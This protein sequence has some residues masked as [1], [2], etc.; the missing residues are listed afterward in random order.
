ML[1]S[2][3]NL[4]W[5]LCSCTPGGF[6]QHTETKLIIG[7]STVDKVMKEFSGEI[8]TIFSS[9]VNFL[10]ETDEVAR[11]MKGFDDLAGLPYCVGSIDG[12]RI[13]WHACPTKKFSEYRCY[14]G[15]TSIFMFAVCSSDRKFTY[16]IIG[17]PGVCG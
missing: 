4:E 5:L 12:T 8:L 10:T 16:I 17:W 9:S 14:E 13:Q 7:A 15:K 2:P 3:W 6:F 1:Q 11:L